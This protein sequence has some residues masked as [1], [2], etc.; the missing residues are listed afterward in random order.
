MATRNLGTL[1]PHLKSQLDFSLAQSAASPF[2]G[3][4]IPG[5][6]PKNKKKKKKGAKGDHN[7][8]WGPYG[9][10]LYAAAPPNFA[11]GIFEADFAVTPPCLPLTYKRPTQ[12]FIA[13]TKSWP[14]KAPSVQRT[15]ILGLLCSINHQLSLRHISCKN[16]VL[17]IVR[18]RTTVLCTGSTSPTMGLVVA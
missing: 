2:S 16:L 9:R 1:Y 15:A 6:K 5:P 8:Q 14:S 11:G 18:G 7:Q 3:A 13:C 17:G 12:K 4:A 10:V